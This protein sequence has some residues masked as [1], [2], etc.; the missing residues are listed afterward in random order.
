M[1][2]ERHLKSSQG[3]EINIFFTVN[4]LVDIGKVSES[5]SFD[6]SAP[7]QGTQRV[8]L[9]VINR[10]PDGAEQVWTVQPESTGVLNGR[11]HFGGDIPGTIQ[12][13][14]THPST[15]SAGQI[16]AVVDGVWQED[17]W[18]NGLHNFNFSWQ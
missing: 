1:T 13:A 3:V 14:K 7:Q 5:I 18:Q 9:V 10:W 8:T 16:A 11:V 15:I 4:E 6:V 17:P 12:V 2:V